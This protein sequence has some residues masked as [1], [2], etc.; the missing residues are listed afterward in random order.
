M[1]RIGVA[2][3]LHRNQRGITGL[4]AGIWIIVWVLVASVFAFAGYHA[5][6]FSSDAVEESPP[7]VVEESTP[8]NTV[9][10]PQPFLGVGWNYT[11]TGAIRITEVVEGSAAQGAGILVGDKIVAIDGREISHEDWFGDLIQQHS[12][13][14]QITVTIHRDVAPLN[15]PSPPLVI[16]IDVIL[17]KR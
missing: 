16:T 14:D 8:S 11:P 4:E 2:Q 1:K 13:G 17:G 3:G 9:D 10:E 7:S 6:L 5:G 15:P 12:P